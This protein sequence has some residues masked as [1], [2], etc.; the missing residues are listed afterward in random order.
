MG[1]AYRGL[2][3]RIG[4]DTSSLQKSMRGLDKTARQ[5]QSSF[6]AASKAL[7]VDGGDVAMQKAQLRLLGQQAETSAAKLA[8]LAQAERQASSQSKALA[9]GTRNAALQ[10]QRFRNSIRSTERQL[11]SFYDA[12][13]RA[14]SGF[15]NG[16]EYNAALNQIRD[17]THAY[18]AGALK[19][20]EFANAVRKGVMTTGF[21]DVFNLGTG[22]TAANKYVTAMRNL[23]AEWHRLSA[24]E[25]SMKGAANIQRTR[26]Q[27]ELLKAEVR[28]AAMEQTRFEASTRQMGRGQFR[29]AANEVNVLDAAIKSLEAD[30]AMLDKALRVDPGNIEAA[31]AKW[32]AT[33]RTVTM[34]NQ[35]VAE[36]QT[37]TKMAGSDEIAKVEKRYG[38]TARAVETVTR[39]LANARGRAASLAEK[40]ELARENL[41]AMRVVGNADGIRRWEAEVQR[42]SARCE[43]ARKDVRNLERTFDTV[44]RSHAAREAG[45]ELEYMRAKANSAREALGGVVTNGRK[46]GQ[47]GASI[48]TLGYSLSA[49]VGS[50]AMML[51]MYAI[52]ASKDVDSAYRDM[53]KT[54]NGTEEEFEHLR[55]AALEFST[56][57]FTSSDQILSIEAIG[58]QLG[59]QAQ[60]LEK[61]GEVVSNLDIATNVDTETMAQNLGQLSNIMNDMDQDLQTGPG[62]FE[63]YSDALVRL[64]NNS[65]AQEDKIQNVMMRIA[66]MGTISGMSTPDLLALSTAVAATGQGAEAAGTAISKTFSNIEGAVNGGDA[67]LDKIRNSSGLT[68]DEIEE[69]TQAVED[70]KASLRDFAEVAGMAPEEFKEA[71]NT[72]PTRAFNAF[73]GG[74]K[75]IDA[76]GGSVDSTLK[77]LGINSVRQKQTLNGLVQTFDVLNDSLLMSNN[78]WKG[79][80][81]V[82]GDAGDAAREA[83][84]KAEGFS[85]QWQQMLN[86]AK[87]L[88]VELTDSLTPAIAFAADALGGLAAGFNGLPDAV[89]LA[90]SGLGLLTAATGPM[91][92][93]VGGSLDGLETI[94]TALFGNSEAWAKVVREQKKGNKELLALTTASSA[95]SGRFDKMGE[96][97]FDAGQKMKKANG[98]VSKFGNAVSKLGLGIA[99]LTPGKI[100][101][102]GA[103]IAGVSVVAGLAY[104]AYSKWAEHCKMVE[105]AH[106]SMSDRIADAMGSASASIDGEVV[107]S[108]DALAGYEEYLEKCAQSHEQLAKAAEQTFSKDKTIEQYAKKITPLLATLG[109]EGSLTKSEFAE[110][111]SAVNGYNNAT[112]DSIKVTKAEDGAIRVLKNGVDVT[113]ES[114][115]NL[116]DQK[117]RAAKASYYDTEYQDTINRVA[118]A[119]S[120]LAD[121]Q[122][123]NPDA[124]EKYLALKKQYDEAMANG[125]NDSADFIHKQMEQYEDS[126]LAQLDLIKQ[127]SDAY[128]ELAQ[129]EQMTSLLKKDSDDMSSF[130]KMVA[131]SDRMQTAFMKSKVA[132]SDFE[133]A[134]RI[135]GDDMGKVYADQDGLI[136]WLR[137]WDGSTKGLIDHLSGQGGLGIAL[138]DVQ[139][140]AMILNGVKIGDKTFTVSD[141]GT[142][143]YGEQQLNDLNQFEL[144]GQTYTLKIDTENATASIESASGEVIELGKTVTDTSDSSEIKVKATTD[145][146]RAEIDKFLSY[147]TGRKITVDVEVNK[148][149]LPSIGDLVSGLTLPTATGG[150]LPSA[151][152]IRHAK[153]GYFVDRPTVIGRTGNVTHIA[154]EAGREYVSMNAK[155]GVVLPLTNPYMRPWVRAVADQMGGSVSTTVNITLAYG[156][157]A[158]A[159]QMVYDIGREMRLHGLMRG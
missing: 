98:D 9:N 28:E 136:E 124:I 88:G 44:N 118:D 116:A 14:K 127:L 122:A 81:D 7:R 106:K 129:K 151:R 70:G 51:G 37:R 121:L 85:G 111:Q 21:D 62:S 103:A 65:A 26:G 56:T 10:E 141:K 67:A 57:H 75:R 27:I 93:F 147:Y 73:I 19:Y 43:S 71:W 115:A 55:Q 22:M 156:A 68:E 13:A 99:S 42:L 34:L 139:K 69:L 146:A 64:G 49:T 23:N 83:Q 102:V 15:S 29:R 132:V 108:E 58:G 137:E 126:A 133:S 60:N 140:K 95:A 109:K 8:R 77:S 25:E 157:D 130:E 12:W 80:G 144:D 154:G 20:N 82:W 142:I 40:L 53:R 86:S 39:N 72:D 32:D 145:E 110:L 105:N 128:L 107:R 45:V 36:L 6:R 79:I 94:K 76:E 11:A 97:V 131:G 91:S 155:G 46:L 54:V 113:A 84:R 41:Q 1:E 89:K 5:L 148:R 138:T 119:Q 35:K 150:M 159:K 90:I 52:Q 78:A 63:A 2:T 125:L 59:I 4:A 17:I 117:R 18:N 3:I 74:L 143:A 66:S 120:K 38:S 158:G 48:K 123:A 24:A 33:V 153:G 47:I 100:L 104:D 101:G 61:F 31:R 112:G 134:I 30:T 135:L 149:V 114:F 92:I 96:R 152:M 16:K 87:Y 50:G